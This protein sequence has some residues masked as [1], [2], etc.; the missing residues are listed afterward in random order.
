LKGK[1]V[2]GRYRLERE[3]GRGAMGVVWEA[4]DQETDET[5][6][7]KVVATTN[8][9][10]RARFRREARA[11]AAVTHPNVVRLIEIGE[12][13]DEAQ[14]L[15]M[16]HLEGQTLRARLEERGKLSVADV[17]RLLRGLVGGLSA[18]H[19]QGIVHRD[20][21]PENVFLVGSHDSIDPKDVRIL[22]FGVAKLTA[23]D[24]EAARTA[25]ASSTGL[26]V[27]TPFYMAP[28]QAFGEAAIDAR[29][30]VWA[31]GIIVYECLSGRRPFESDNVGRVLRAVA[32]GKLVPL[33]SA[34]PEL[35]SSVVDLVESMLAVDPKE[36]PHDLEALVRAFDGA[37]S[38]APRRSRLAIV[39]VM[40]GVAA[41][42]GGIAL[43]RAPSEPSTAESEPTATSHAIVRDEPRPLEGAAPIPSASTAPIVPPVVRPRIDPPGGARD[44]GSGIEDA[45]HIDPFHG[46]AIDPPF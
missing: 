14:L 13:E 18:A 41:V 9:L 46:L 44:A 3:L 11:A 42:G 16:E 35:S 17:A 38:S 45:T 25:G 4:Y 15:V 31:L 34:A 40:L 37:V 23:F 22:D 36:R 7:V 43:V 12:T 27:G 32:T 24:G 30:D 5:V 29:A 6:A 10:M 39:G 2:L 33:R 20:L 8:A 1:L 21:K 26:M 28:E 19:E